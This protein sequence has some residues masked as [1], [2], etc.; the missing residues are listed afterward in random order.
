MPP[1][2]RFFITVDND[3]RQVFPLYGDKTSLVHTLEKEQQLY[4]TSLDG[5]FKFVKDD[6]D[7][8]MSKPFD[9]IVNVTIERSV[10]FGKTYSQYFIGKFV[11]TDCT[12]NEVDKI[13]KVSITPVDGYENIM[14][15]LDKE[16]DL[17]SLAPAM[18][19]VYLYK[20]PA[21]Q[22][23]VTDTDVVT[24]F[25]GGTYF[26]QQ[27]TGKY[28]S[29]EVED[30][31]FSLLRKITYI[32]VN[33]SGTGTGGYEGHY[34]K[35]A[36][37]EY[38]N[39]E[40]R[41]KIVVDS[42]D[43]VRV[44]GS[45]NGHIYDTVISTDGYIKTALDN[46]DYIIFTAPRS[47]DGKIFSYGSSEINTGLEYASIYARILTDSNSTAYETFEIP[48]DDIVTDNSNYKKC[49]SI[50]GNIG[51]EII[52]HTRLTSTPTEW[53]LYQPGLYYT[54]PSSIAHGHQYYP[55]GKSAWGSFSLWL[56]FI[57]L[58]DAL[59]E[60][61]DKKYMLKHAYTLAGCIKVLLA[62]VAPELT[63][64][65]SALYS[66][67]FY[68]TY[69]P[70]SH[71]KFGLFITPI[72]NV[73]KGEYDQPAQRAIIT[74]RNIFDMLKACYRCYWFVDRGRLRIEHVSFFRNGLNYLALADAGIDVSNIIEPKTEKPWTTAANSYYFDKLNIPEYLQFKW[75]DSVTKPFDG[76]PIEVLSN[77]VEKGNV[78]EINVQ[79]FSSDIDLMLLNPESFS[80]DNF[81]LLAAVDYGDSYEL[82]FTYLEVDNYKY[83]LQNGL[84][85]FM[86]LHVRY[87]TMDLPA[88][89]VKINNE[90]YIADNKHV[91]R[92]KLQQVKFPAGL[93]QINPMQLIRT[94]LGDGLADSI[95][96]NLSS[97]IANVTLRYDNE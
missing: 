33:S 37:N 26:E 57:N 6:F 81:A 32:N 88:N 42:R 71:D 73:T 72:T 62:K 28:T 34:F 39:I 58:N 10:D 91:K 30:F 7:F 65:E 86:Y 3:T 67:F 21:L 49:L 59:N 14:A 44:L 31:H 29:E 4:R 27:S 66:R 76:Y 50:S 90:E 54:K 24:T 41:V 1:K 87:Y 53:G 89:R 96:I 47:D 80:K 35:V 74:L 97:Q 25:V 5:E 75:A 8:I 51:D 13:L 55:I 11:R 82:P 52:M 43:S 17:I 18:Q 40:K 16:F 93:S 2:Y 94:K 20:R 56:P 60:N 23:Y 92:N 61:L 64:D 45:S 9:S 77:F 68:E 83:A 78:E 12:I 85:S 63:F 46:L 36:D 19:S 38:E 48:D 95:S 22:V 69:N 70:I 15:G 79:K 84:L